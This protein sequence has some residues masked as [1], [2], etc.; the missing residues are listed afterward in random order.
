MRLDGARMQ[1]THALYWQCFF[2]FLDKC[3][4]NYVII[5]VMSSILNHAACRRGPYLLIYPFTIVIFLFK[6]PIDCKLSKEFG[7][8]R[9]K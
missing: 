4:E 5:G 1:S 7:L 8:S 9:E 3:I 2:G 6:I